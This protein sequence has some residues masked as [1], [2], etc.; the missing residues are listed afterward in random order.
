MRKSFDAARALVQTFKDQLDGDACTQRRDEACSISFCSSVD[1][2]ARRSA[3][4]SEHQIE[5]LKGGGVHLSWPLEARRRR[6]ARRDLSTAPS[7]CLAGL[8]LPPRFSMPTCGNSFVGTSAEYGPSAGTHT[9]GS[10]PQEALCT[11]ERELRAV[12]HQ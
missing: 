11:Q 10:S 2:Q 4:N 5:S 12:D 1:V 9:K 8:G 6:A 7:W 3:A